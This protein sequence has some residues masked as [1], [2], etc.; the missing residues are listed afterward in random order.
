MLRYYKNKAFFLLSLKIQL[1]LPEKRRHRLSATTDYK[2]GFGSR[3]LRNTG[4]TINPDPH[5]CIVGWSVEFFF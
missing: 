2:I 5:H 4:S 3:W 1:E